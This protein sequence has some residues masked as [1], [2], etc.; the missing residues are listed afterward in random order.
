[1]QAEDNTTPPL[2]EFDPYE[3]SYQ[4][5]IDK[6]IS[7]GGQ[8][9]DFYMQVKA[10]LLLEIAQHR[11]GRDPRDLSFLDVGCGVGITCGLLVDRVGEMHG[12]DVSAGVIRTARKS[13]PTAAFEVYD[14]VR[15]PYPD[16]T[17]D[18]VYVICV[19]HHVPPERWEPFL[20]EL[21]R[22][23]KPEGVVVVM[24]HNGL[25][26]A[27]RHVVNNCVFDKD[28]V[29]IS[30]GRLGRLFGALQA[31]VLDKRYFLFFPFKGGLF[32]KLDRLLSAIPMGAQYYVTAQKQPAPPA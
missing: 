8:S 6:A 29:L 3:S 24:E 30:A 10:D 20:A 26:P 32:R 9:H 31:R 13:N 1:M 16:H 11:V 5:E 4:E 18:V 23:V 17:F 12:V 28:A 2:T 25:N 15:L 14:G 27:T 19:I 21:L 22:V 7:F